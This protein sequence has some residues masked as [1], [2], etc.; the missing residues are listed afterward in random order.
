LGKLPDSK[1]DDLVVTKFKSLRDQAETFVKTT[2]PRKA[3]VTSCESRL[4]DE[5]YVEWI[6]SWK[7]SAHGKIDTIELVSDR[8][9]SGLNSSINVIFAQ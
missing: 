6:V 1:T 3:V 7:S 8:R 5:S 2:C 4:L 9:F